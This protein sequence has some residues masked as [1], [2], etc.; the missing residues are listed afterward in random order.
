MA[1]KTVSFAIIAALLAGQGAALPA[2]PFSENINPLIEARGTCK[3]LP[4]KEV[5][6]TDADFSSD[7]GILKRWTEDEFSKFVKRGR[8]PLNWCAEEKDYHV[9]LETEPYPEPKLICDPKS[10]TYHNP[11][12]KTFGF[13]DKKSF[14][15]Y[16]FKEQPLPSPTNTGDYDT[17]HL[18]EG[19]M[20][21]TFT[22]KIS[23]ASKKTLEDPKTKDK[24]SVC[25]YLTRWFNELPASEELKTVNGKKLASAGNDGNQGLIW[26]ASIYPQKTDQD[27]TEFGLLDKQVNIAKGGLWTGGNGIDMGDMEKNTK[28]LTDD[29]TPKF[30]PA[31][32]IKKNFETA[33]FKFKVILGNRV[34]HRDTWVR[35]TL[36]LQSN[37]MAD[38]LD[39]LETE[40]AKK[41]IKE[42]D[43]NKKTITWD[44]YK[45]QGLKAKWNSHMKDTT[46]NLVSTINKN[47][48]KSYEYLEKAMKAFEDEAGKTKDKTLKDTLNQLVCSIK[49]A[50]KAYNAEKAHTLTSITF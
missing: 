3:G 20:L 2:T 9:P 47:F 1:F 5:K 44:K 11:Q 22:K 30:K 31:N 50:E 19:Q 24:V 40:M 6:L 26:L 27:M 7:S 42:T 36:K 45:K 37:R 13:T 32:E 18:L 25:G 10:K 17:E 33:L 48:E 12:C 46:D 28:W 49:E 15:D 43:K 23:D 39:G 8:K 38:M 34:Y 29:K 14:T 35:D 4:S 16:E 41:Q 21:N